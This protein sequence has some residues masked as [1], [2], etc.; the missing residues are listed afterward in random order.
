MRGEG[1]RPPCKTQASGRG[2]DHRGRGRT[3]K[4]DR[5]SGF[6]LLGSRCCRSGKSESI[7]ER[8]SVE[9]G[10]GSRRSA[11]NFDVCAVNKRSCVRLAA[12]AGLPLGALGPLAA[13]QSIGAEARYQTFDD[14]H[15]CC[16]AAVAARPL[17]RYRAGQPIS[18]TRRAAAVVGSGVRWRLTP[19]VEMSQE[20]KATAA[21]TISRSAC[22]LQQ[23]VQVSLSQS[24]RNENGLAE[25]GSS[26]SRTRRL[27][28]RA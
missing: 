22:Q 10:L 21:S 16:G 25:P 27:I 14:E 11:G 8:L 13:R 7:G 2:I 5:P 20:K 9:G 4:E 15:I 28:W 26:R 3:V 18:K 23:F 17:L 24:Y 1:A 19:G 12:E 6:I